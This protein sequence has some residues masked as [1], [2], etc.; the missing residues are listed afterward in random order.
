M[1]VPVRRAHLLVYPSLVLVLSAQTTGGVFVSALHSDWMELA[2]AKL[3]PPIV[4]VDS[5][6]QGFLGVVLAYLL[7]VLPLAVLAMVIVRLDIRPFV[8]AMR[9][10][11]AYRLRLAGELLPIVWPTLTIAVAL[12]TGLV[13][14]RSAPAIFIDV[15]GRLAL[16]PL[17][18]QSQVA[19]AADGQAFGL[20]I[21]MS[22]LVI[23]LL[24]VA[25]VLWIEVRRKRWRSSSTV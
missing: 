13:L 22:M 2:G 5:L 24:A 7:L 1:A 17:A 21:I 11:G 4:G 16:T 14:T 8:A 15:G 23:S 18:V 19:A 9:D 20:S 12:L 25:G 10:A 6:Y 3:V